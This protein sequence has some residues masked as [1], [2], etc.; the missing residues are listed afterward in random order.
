MTLLQSFTGSCWFCRIS[1]FY[2]ASILFFWSSFVNAWRFKWVQHFAQ[3]SQTEDGW[4]LTV[5]LWFCRIR[6]FCLLSIPYFVR[7]PRFWKVKWVRLALTLWGRGYPV[8]SCVHF[9]HFV[10][11][12][13][14]KNKNWHNFHS[15]TKWGKWTQ[16]STG[17]NPVLK[18]LTSR[19]F[20][21]GG[22]VEIDRHYAVLQDQCLIP[23]FDPLYLSGFS[24]FSRLTLS[25]HRRG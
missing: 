12:W 25:K 2:V 4:G 1:V 15:K 7:F 23:P 20:S 8:L 14:I 22:W 17:Y 24:G 9:P 3:I 21:D 6:F 10:F 18:G 16:V 13:K 5:A 11:E 19:S